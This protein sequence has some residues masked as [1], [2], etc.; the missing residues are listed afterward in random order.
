MTAVVCLESDSQLY[1]RR[2]NMHSLSV[3]LAR[4]PRF[5]HR[6][7]ASSHELTPFS[8]L[9]RGEVHALPHDAPSSHA[10]TAASRRPPALAQPKS[11]RTSLG[12]SSGS[13]ARVYTDACHAPVST[14]PTSW[15]PRSPTVVRSPHA[16]IIRQQAESAQAR[17]AEM[18][19]AWESAERAS[20]SS[21][22]DFT[23]AQ[24]T[25]KERGQHAASCDGENRRGDEEISPR[26]LALKLCSSKLG[27][28]TFLS[29]AASRLASQPTNLSRPSQGGGGARDMHGPGTKEASRSFREMLREIQRGVESGAC[30]NTFSAIGAPSASSA[31]R[32]ATIDATPSLHRCA[33]SLTSISAQDVF[34]TG[35]I[36]PEASSA[37]ASNNGA[38]VGI[39]DAAR[40]ANADCGSILTRP[41][42]F[43][44]DACEE[45]GIKR[46]GLEGVR[47]D[48]LTDDNG[49]QDR[50][51]ATPTGF[52]ARFQ[53]PPIGSN[54]LH[55]P[56]AGEAVGAGRRLVKQWGSA[57]SIPLSPAAQSQL[58][59]RS[60]NCS[61]AN[62]LRPDCLSPTDATMGRESPPA[63]VPCLL[64]RHTSMTT[65]DVCSGGTD[66]AA[67][68]HR[69]KVSFKS[70]V[71][72][73]TYMCVET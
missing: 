53:G 39:A 41:H 71:Q 2:K 25:E 10:S 15:Q 51:Q 31:Q 49:D 69:R 13:C 67:R 63:P 22:G 65:S 55:A 45:Q 43:V 4:V 42:F 16:E 64:R 9:L 62:S 57:N 44:A 19:R 7:S 52:N 14:S 56:R 48:D 70:T 72:V 17:E 68:G 27:W 59:Y 66:Q 28:R 6:R 40:A 35:G 3:D 32:D 54:K 20:E 50:R 60:K 8:S 11:R 73:R 26:S 30:K 36:F 61:S 33:R 21:A 29:P 58:T 23:A 38:S 12:G 18:D 46:T 34:P 37:V 24:P 5:D 47:E 1:R